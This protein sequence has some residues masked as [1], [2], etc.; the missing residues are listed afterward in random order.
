MIQE[1]STDG[2]KTYSARLAPS[3][4]VDLS[5]VNINAIATL[6]TP[7]SG[8]KLRLHGGCIS[9]SAAGAVLF[10]DNAVSA[11]VFRTPKL[12][13]DTPYNFALD[14]PAALAAADNVLKGTGASGATITGTLFVSEE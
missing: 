2:G 6:V 13:A 12:A 8:K 3:R 7:A 11:F 5:A 9:V 10:E 14:Q 1:V 4:R